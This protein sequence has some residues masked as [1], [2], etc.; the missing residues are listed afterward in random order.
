MAV[1]LHPG[2]DDIHRERHDLYIVKRRQQIVM[3]GS[4]QECDDIVEAPLCQYLKC[5]LSAALQRDLRDFDAPL[6]HDKKLLHQLFRRVE[7][8]APGK[9]DYLPVFFYILIQGTGDDGGKYLLHLTSFF[10][11]STEN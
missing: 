2:A 1:V 6:Q 11:D 7:E 4:I 9:I 10:G 5:L 3:S 8:I